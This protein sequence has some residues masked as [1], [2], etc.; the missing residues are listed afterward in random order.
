MQMI[1]KPSRRIHRKGQANVTSLVDIAL[2]L[3]IFFI[4]TLPVLMESGIMVKAPS[5]A[6]VGS[7]Q[8]ADEF[9]VSIYI[10]EDGRYILNESP[11]TREQLESLVGELLKRSIEKLVVVR[12]DGAVMHEKVVEV[13]DMAKQKGA[14]KLA[15]I[16][17]KPMGG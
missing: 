15:L 6:V 17:G 13:L 7:N 16:R 8:P 4:V 12:A 11:V 3:V 9:K 5:V 2:S 10:T 14:M 1:K